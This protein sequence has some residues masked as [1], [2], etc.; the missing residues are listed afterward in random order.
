MWCGAK[1]NS[2]TTILASALLFWAYVY[3]LGE[4]RIMWNCLCCERLPSGVWL[5]IVQAFQSFC[6]CVKNVLVWSSLG[7]MHLSN[8]KHIQGL[9][10]PPGL[11][12]ESGDP[13]PQV[14][15]SVAHHPSPY[16]P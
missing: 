7:L 13:G 16:S 5:Y 11:K 10:G 9:P 14:R 12:G 15:H 4:C 1:K 3:A 2:R 6:N 8:V